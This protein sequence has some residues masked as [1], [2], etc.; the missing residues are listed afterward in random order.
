[1][2][3]DHGGVKKAYLDAAPFALFA[4]RPHLSVRRFLGRHDD[5]LKVVNCRELSS[6]SS[7]YCE[8]KTS[9]VLP[10]ARG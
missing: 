2:Y 6:P 3:S 5:A 8:L 1:V 10:L 4:A 9:A 7:A